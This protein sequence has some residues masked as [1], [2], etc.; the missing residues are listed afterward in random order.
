MGDK[1]E[2]LVNRLF[3]GG[4]FIGAGCIAAVLGLVPTL[5]GEPLYMKRAGGPV[6][7]GFAFLVSAVLILIG[8]VF[9]AWAI[10]GK[11]TD[12]S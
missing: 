3:K 12:K 9:V 10:V 5:S 6:E 4:M 7:P 2:L 11:L 1:T 8:I